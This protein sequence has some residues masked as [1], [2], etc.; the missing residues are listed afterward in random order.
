MSL[1]QVICKRNEGFGGALKRFWVFA[2]ALSFWRPKRDATDFFLI[3]F[4][5][6]D[7][8]HSSHHSAL[9]G[10]GQSNVRI[11]PSE[12]FR[13][14]NFQLTEGSNNSHVNHGTEA[15][16]WLVVDLPSE[17]Y[18]SQMRWWHSQLNRKNIDM[19]QTTNQVG[20]PSL[21]F[22]MIFHWCPCRKS[23]PNQS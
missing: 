15:T 3:L 13:S 22:N 9:C 11:N 6:I 5:P 8:N 12:I 14:W 4:S 23:K 7:M 19:F 1:L 10:K 2:W 21:C 18:E 17:K 20:I 16:S